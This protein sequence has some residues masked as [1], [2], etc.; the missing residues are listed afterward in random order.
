MIS[1]PPRGD[2]FTG[3]AVNLT[4]SEYVPAS[5]IVS[6]EPLMLNEISDGLAGKAK[7]TRGFGLGNVLIILA[8]ALYNS[9]D[10]SK[11]KQIVGSG[12]V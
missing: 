10:A 1:F 2:T 11:C 8:H 6:L 9:A 3:I 4:L 12:S 7:L 5:D